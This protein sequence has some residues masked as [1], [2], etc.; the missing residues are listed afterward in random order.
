MCVRIRGI[1]SEFAILLIPCFLRFKHT[2]LLNS[3]THRH[4]PPTSHPL[5]F[6]SSLSSLLFLSLPSIVSLAPAL[7]LIPRH[8]SRSPLHRHTKTT[9]HPHHVLTSTQVATP[10]TPYLH[11][12]YPRSTPTSTSLRRHHD[13]PTRTTRSRSPSRRCA[14][15]PFAIESLSRYTTIVLT[16]VPPPGIVQA[17]NVSH[18]RRLG[19]AP[20]VRR[21]QSH[22]YWPL[23]CASS[24]W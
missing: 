12:L 6:S 7:S 18:Q 16:N 9:I 22:V 17:A 20:K 19:Q 14:R 23:T 10:T 1:D 24:G 8:T 13:R 15:I 2:H 3:T 11:C 5:L 21:R 4:W